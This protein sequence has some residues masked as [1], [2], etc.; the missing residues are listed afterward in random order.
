MNNTPIVVLLTGLSGSGKTT[1][2]NLVHNKLQRLG[3]NSILLDGDTFREKYAPDLGFSKTD[4]AKNLEFAGSIAKEYI[5]SGIDIILMS[6][7]APY[8][9][10]RIKLQKYI[11]PYRFKEVYLS[12]TLE[13]CEDRDVKGLYKKARSGKIQNFT[14][15]GDEYE[16][17]T[18]P[19][20]IIPTHEWDIERCVDSIFSTILD[21]D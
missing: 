14:G 19:S 10:D 13:V 7:I 20:L 3:Y 5:K 8:S 11:Y 21:Y 17:P 18:N 15:I 12:S 16:I 9:T 6:F 4:R 2:G 1:L